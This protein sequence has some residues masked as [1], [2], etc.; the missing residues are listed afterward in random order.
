MAEFNYYYDETHP[1]KPFSSESVA[2]KGSLPPLNAIRT[3]PPAKQAGKWPCFK[4]GAWSMVD[5]HRG[6]T[7]YVN[8][9]RTE[10]KDIGPYPSGWSATAPPPTEEELTERA[11][12]ECLAKLNDLDR[13]S[14]RSIRAIEVLKE[15]I[16]EN[17]GLTDP[18][19][20]SAQLAAEKAYLAG[21]EE[22]A[23]EERAKLATLRGE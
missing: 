21:L 22:Q 1:L 3:A 8:G 20:L 5:D 2:N 15:R 14:T 12:D 16:A 23:K 10:I 18:D 17:V 11:I 13:K 6:E 19:G 7:G 9:V 4:N